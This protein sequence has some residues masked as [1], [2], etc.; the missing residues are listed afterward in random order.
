[1]AVHRLERTQIVPISTEKAFGFF[2]DPGNLEKL[3]PDSVHFQ[4]AEPPPDKLSPGSILRYRLRLYAVPV[5]WRTRI[6]SVDEPN[7]FVDVQEKGPYA[8]W[9]HT[10]RFRTI[11]ATHT[12]IRDQVEF[13]MPLGILGEIAYRTFVARSL[14]QI[15][16]YREEALRTLF[17]E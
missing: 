6:E 5:N 3:T 16:D 4:F 7:E 13:T 14:R 2:S 10:H 17:P 8:S 11:D 9:R 15:F 12:E 1:M